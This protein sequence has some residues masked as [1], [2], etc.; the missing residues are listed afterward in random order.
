M[1]SPKST[2]R[3]VLKQDAAPDVYKAVMLPDSDGCLGAFA[4]QAPANK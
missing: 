2:G 3:V 1:G 4:A